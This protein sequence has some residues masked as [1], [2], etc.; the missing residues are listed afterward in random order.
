M[1]ILPNETKG[2]RLVSMKRWSYIAAT[3]ISDFEQYEGGKMLWQKIA[4][5]SDQIAVFV[6]DTEQEHSGLMMAAR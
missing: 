4:R 6:L 2:W 1:S 3:L 5:E